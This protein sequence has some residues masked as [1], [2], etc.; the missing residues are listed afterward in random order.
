VKKFLI[1]AIACFILMVATFA[2]CKITLG[3]AA[4]EV[5]ATAADVKG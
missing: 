3:S 5:R 4:S 2:I 1:G